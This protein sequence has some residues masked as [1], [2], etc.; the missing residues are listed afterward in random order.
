M[1]LLSPEA[2]AAHQ[3]HFIALWTDSSH[4]YALY[5][6][7]ELVAVELQDGAY[8]TLHYPGAN[9][10][11][12]L[13]K[14]LNGHKATGFTETRTAVEHFRELDG[15]APWPDFKAPEV[16]GVHQVAVGPIHAGIIE[17][18]HFRFSVVG[19]QVLKLEA[20]LGYA[21]KG[22]LGL[23]RGKSAR[24]AARYAARIS[25]DSTVAHSIA[26]ARAA[27]E[28]LGTQ[29]PERAVSLRALMAEMERLANHT[30][31]I[32]AMAGDA[33]FAFLDSRF[34]LIREYLCAA[35]QVA[36]G[37]RLMMDVV[38]P[39]GVAGD[40]AEGGADAMEDALHAL[41]QELPSLTRVFEDYAS[42]QDRV[43]GTGLVPPELAASYFA[44]GYVGR[45][46]G[47]NRDARV[48]PGYPPY[49]ELGLA[50]PVEQDGDVAAR[51]KIRLREIPESIR[52]IRVILEALPEGTVA[53]APNA[54]SGM[55]LG[56]AES[57][58]GP[59]WHWLKID[60]GQIQDAFV[61]DASTLHWPLLE[62]AAT[63]AILADFPLIN[64]SINGSYSGVDL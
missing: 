61:A 23:M 29:V 33:G 15:R 60:N 64:K 11:Q 16:E 42:L 52:L 46:S 53:L 13:A 1:K 54:A 38:V 19:D 40:L 56:V 6:P 24:Q 48:M 28:A 50:V 8:P 12:R 37:H 20:R 47:Q 39:G 45:A 51:I 43:V 35:A 3:G 49:G 25:G 26:F 58:R 5:E 10:F 55:G 63:T 32:G 2:W 4:A 34:A 7:D 17:P 36:F 57:F 62:H 41:E 59:V 27:E 30:S 18:G 14:D 21:H 44:G 22:T 9:W 31:D